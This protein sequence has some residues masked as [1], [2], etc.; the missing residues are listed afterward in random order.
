MEPCLLA[1]RKRELQVRFT[2]LLVNLFT[3]IPDVYE[4]QCNFEI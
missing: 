2:A 4:A 1:Y 3:Q